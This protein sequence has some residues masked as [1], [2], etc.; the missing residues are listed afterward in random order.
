MEKKRHHYVPISYLRYFCAEDG[1]LSVYRKDEPLT[2]FRQAPQNTAFHKYYHSQPLPN[3]KMDHNTLEDLFSTLEDDWPPLIERLQRGENVNDS[4]EYLLTFVGLQRVRVPATRE[5]FEIVRAASVMATAKF[6]DAKGKLPPKPEG[7]ED[8][9]DRSQ[10]S[11]DPAITLQDM[12]AAL[13]G[14]GTVMGRLGFRVLRNRT[15]IPF[16]TSDNPVI[17]FDPSAADSHLRPYTLRPNGP[18]ELLFPLSPRL[19]LHGHSK[20]TE[21]FGSRGLGYADLV[22]PNEAK[23]INRFVCRF[24][25]RAVF[26]N[27]G[28]FDRLVRRFAQFSPVVVSETIQEGGAAFT[29]SRSIFGERKKMPKWE[30]PTENEG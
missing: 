7:F 28:G 18:A 8:I 11:I 20:R 10:I 5:S 27:A 25:Y 29:T 9:L 3:G 19:L 1:M 13:R 26:S 2:V 22:R 21:R 14:V 23:K 17:Y 12:P 6:L 24:A 4:L 15:A 30:A 16:L